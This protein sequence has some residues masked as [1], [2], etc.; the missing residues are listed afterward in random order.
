MSTSAGKRTGL[1]V[2]LVAAVLALSGCQ[3]DTG[4][5][6][7]AA[8]RPEKAPTQS[9]AAATKQLTASYGKTAAAGSAKVRMTVTAP[10]LLKSG[11]T[12]ASGVMGWDP[13][14]SLDLAVS[15][16][17]LRAA[18]PDAG[19]RSRMVMRDDVMYLDMGDAVSEQTDGRGWLK[20]D[21]AKND[22]G[23]VSMFTGGLE[24]AN[25]DPAR[26]LALLLDSPSLKHTGAQRVDGVR[27]QHYRGTLTLDEILEA[28]GSAGVLSGKERGELGTQLKKAG[29]KGYA[30]EV[31]VGS[32]GYPVKTRLGLDS[33]MGRTTFVTHYADYG[34]KASVQAPPAEETFDV[35]KKLQEL[36]EKMT[37]AGDDAEAEAGGGATA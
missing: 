13:A 37:G 28:Q 20:L 35:S 3:G 7:A 34:A 30:T 14:E 22:G 21:L 17:L 33:P 10:G 4:A 9:R 15:S 23:L 18:A 29:I 19:E 36:G 25:Q 11:E 31:W 16:P 1:S 27:A 8:E 24:H 2:T 12:K 6:P 32:N 26:Q 5:E